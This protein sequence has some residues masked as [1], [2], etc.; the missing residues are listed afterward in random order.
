M[1]LHRPVRRSVRLQGHA[2]DGGLYFV[3]ICTHLKRCLFGS[4][5]DGDVVLDRAGRI[6]HE[7]WT[8]TARL[9]AEVALDA[10]VVMPNHVHALIGIVPA[11]PQP[12]APAG[13]ARCAPT[14]GGAPRRFGAMAHGTLPAVV[15]A[16][17]SAVTRRVRAEADPAFG[18]QRGYHEH[19][20][21]DDRA[22]KRIRRYI[23]ENPQRWTAAGHHPT[24]GPGVQRQALRTD[25]TPASPQPGS[26][27]DP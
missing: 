5:V 16:Y 24:R 23:Q 21:R 3:T 27:T 19:I 26:R 25:P 9:R 8:R 20:V 15:R 17:K 6:A 4:V 2:Y 14:H 7:E 13:T 1:R 12:A 22:L 11:G 10:F 18:W